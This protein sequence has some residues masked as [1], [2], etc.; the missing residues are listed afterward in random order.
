MVIASV[1]LE[2]HPS[3]R[4]QVLLFSEISTLNFASFHPVPNWSSSTFEYQKWA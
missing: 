2:L 4:N 1:H 3:K